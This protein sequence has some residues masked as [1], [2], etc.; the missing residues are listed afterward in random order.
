M[1]D[2]LGMSLKAYQ[3]FEN[4]ITKLD[5][6]RLKSVAQILDVDVEDLINAEDSGVFIAEIKNNSVGYNGS[7]VTIHNPESQNEKELFEKIIAAKDEQ[8]K[9]LTSI[10]EKYEKLIEILQNK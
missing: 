3:N 1:A 6:D 9:A 10:N 4:G 2:K 7:S 8:I 5:Y